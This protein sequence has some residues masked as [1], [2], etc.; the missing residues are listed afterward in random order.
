[1]SKKTTKIVEKKKLKI[2]KGG[3]KKATKIIDT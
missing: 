1:M 2:V 3:E